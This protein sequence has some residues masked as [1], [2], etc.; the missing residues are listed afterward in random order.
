MQVLHSGADFFCAAG[1]FL[2][3]ADESAV[4]AALADERRE[5]SWREESAR[6]RR[7]LGDLAYFGGMV[8]VEG[9]E[10]ETGRGRGSVGQG[11]EHKSKSGTLSRKC[12]ES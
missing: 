6:W 8:N 1:F 11:K 10:G 5:R 12:V 7:V 9:V 3:F 2:A 4:L